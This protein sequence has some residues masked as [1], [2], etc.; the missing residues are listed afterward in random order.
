LV[1]VFLLRPRQPQAPVQPIEF[2]HRIHAGDN[3]I[4][5]SYCHAGVSR[6]AAAGVPSVAACYECHR[7]V[8]LR[9][10]EIAK[11]F[12]HWEGRQPIRWIRVHSLPDHAYFSHKRHTLAGVECE[13]CHGDVAG[14]DR[15]AQ[16]SALTMG[17]CVN[18]HQERAAP[19]ECSTCHQ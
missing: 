3:Q 10:P 4:S 12:T 19:L 8:T 1:G 6:S 5:C 15:V 16:R 13:S 14:M 18:C 7:G 9:S 11:V 2:S 17:W